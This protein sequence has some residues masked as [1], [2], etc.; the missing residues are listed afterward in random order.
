MNEQIKELAIIAGS[1]GFKQVE[2]YEEDP[3]TGDSNWVTKLKLDTE[4]IDLE[5]FAE[6]IIRECAKI[7]EEYV[8]KEN[9]KLVEEVVI[10]AYDLQDKIKEHFG[11]EP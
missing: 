1:E 8:R 3:E 9:N 6:L 4:S 11:V 5:K 7:A 10:S 2:G